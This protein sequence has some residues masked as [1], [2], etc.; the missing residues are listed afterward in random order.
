MH[1]TSTY[2]SPIFGSSPSHCYLALNALLSSLLVGHEWAGY[3]AARKTLRVTFPQGI[4]RSA[5][6]ISLPLKYG[7]IL[8]ASMSLLHWTVSQSI[9]VIRI[10][11]QYSNGSPDTR[12]TITASCW[13]PLAI[14]ICM[15]S[16]SSL[17]QIRSEARTDVFD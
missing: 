17:T 12:S 4:Q 15:F 1:C 6:F 7:I 14:I 3:S 13:S 16:S 2:S 10:D 9:F 8:T 11:S 5:Y